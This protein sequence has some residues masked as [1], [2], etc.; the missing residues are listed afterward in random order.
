MNFLS[1]VSSK[2]ILSL[3][4]TFRHFVEFLNF[5]ELVKVMS[6][7]EEQWTKGTFPGWM[8]KSFWI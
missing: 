3:L 5:Q 4:R 1:R 6:E 7:F 8:V 2:I